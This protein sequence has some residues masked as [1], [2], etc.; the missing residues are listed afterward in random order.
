DRGRR[1]RL[2]RPRLV[3][4]E[5]RRVTDGMAGLGSRPHQLRLSVDA[6]KGE[7]AAP[8]RGRGVRLAPLAASG[9]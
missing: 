7:W 4:A 8:W 9:A 3:G 5:G 6:D 2:L 1:G